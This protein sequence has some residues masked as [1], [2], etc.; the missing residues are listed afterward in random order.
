MKKYTVN[1]EAAAGTC[2]LVAVALDAAAIGRESRRRR[3]TQPQAR[4]LVRKKIDPIM[5]KK[6][7]YEKKIDPIGFLHGFVSPE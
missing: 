5:R 6:S 4:F 7:W 2:A 1:T 3:V